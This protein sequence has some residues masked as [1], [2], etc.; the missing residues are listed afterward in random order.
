MVGASVLA[1]ASS[2]PLALTVNVR[3]AGSGSEVTSAAAVEAH[4]VGRRRHAHGGGSAV[5]HGS[6]GRALLGTETST[7]IPNAVAVGLADF[8]GLSTEAAASLAGGL[9]GV[10]VAGGL[11]L[12]F[13]ESEGVVGVDED[14]RAGSGAS[15]GF[16]IPHAAS[17]EDA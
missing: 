11:T 2:G 8:G 9:S 5:H 13:G 15:G 6:D 14:L 7:L 16:R 1:D 4:G 10:E 17:V 12:A 3:V